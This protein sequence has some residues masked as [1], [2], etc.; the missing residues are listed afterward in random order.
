VL[1][2]LRPKGAPQKS[3]HKAIYFISQMLG[4][5]THQNLKKKCKNVGKPN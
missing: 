3:G 2:A 4:S 1:R 5:E